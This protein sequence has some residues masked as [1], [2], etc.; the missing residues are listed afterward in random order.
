MIVQ[1]AVIVHRPVNVAAD[2]QVIAGIYHIQYF[3]TD[4]SQ[5]KQWMARFNGVTMNNLESYL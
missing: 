3:N 1:H 2:K 5:L 4:D